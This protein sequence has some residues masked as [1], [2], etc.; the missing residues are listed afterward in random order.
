MSFLNNVWDNFSND[1][2]KLTQL[3]IWLFVTN[4]VNVEYVHSYTHG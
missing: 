4:K 1:I 2:L 3:I